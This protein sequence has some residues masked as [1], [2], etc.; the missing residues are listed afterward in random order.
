MP[1]TIMIGTLNLF[2]LNWLEGWCAANTER[3]NVQPQ[4]VSV[5]KTQKGKAS[6]AVAES[7]S[8]NYWRVATRFP[9]L[10]ST[11]ELA[12]GWWGELFADQVTSAHTDDRPYL[13][14]PLQGRYHVVPYP[15]QH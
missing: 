7:G 10:S 12:L 13:S 6:N 3:N 8:C 4:K 15:T 14:R 5:Q 1:D 2:K 11:C 9:S